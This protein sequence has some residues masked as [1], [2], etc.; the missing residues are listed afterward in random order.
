MTEEE[1]DTAMKPAYPT[2]DHRFGGM[3][4]M[5]YFA[6]QAL[7]G[8]MKEYELFTDVEDK[9]IVKEAYDLADAMIR[10]KIKREA[11]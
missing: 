5:D 8:K 6:G 9:D 11:E 4:L 7:V 1:K 3:T 2:P 10:E